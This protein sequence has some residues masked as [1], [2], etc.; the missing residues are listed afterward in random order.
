MVKKKDRLSG[1]RCINVRGKK[2]CAACWQGRQGVLRYTRV[3]K[4]CVYLLEHP[5]LKDLIHFSFSYPFFTLLHKGDSIDFCT[6]LVLSLA[7]LI[8]HLTLHDFRGFYLNIACFVDKAD[9]LVTDNI[10]MSLMQRART[11]NQKDPARRRRTRG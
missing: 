5:L 3:A 7:Y 9:G 6:V 10:R 4:L 1:K 8:S 11:S 2:R